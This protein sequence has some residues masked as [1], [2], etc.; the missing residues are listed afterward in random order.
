MQIGNWSTDAGRLDV[1]QHIPASDRDLDYAQL[2]RHAI[3]MTDETETFFV[4]SLAEITE[5]KLADRNRPDDDTPLNLG[6]RTAGRGASV[7]REASARG[8]RF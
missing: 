8:G 6:R 1:L 4:A 7:R 3:E 5:S 2:R